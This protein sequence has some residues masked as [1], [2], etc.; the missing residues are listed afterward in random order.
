MSIEPLARAQAE[1]DNVTKGSEG[2]N[3][4]FSSNISNCKTFCCTRNQSTN[5]SRSSN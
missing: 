3:I 1:N 4:R 2:I 5:Q